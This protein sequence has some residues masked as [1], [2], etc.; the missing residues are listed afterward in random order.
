MLQLEGK[1]F[2]IMGVANK[3]S[4]AWAIA[5][6]LHRAGAQL[7]FSYQGERLEK[8]VRR[9]V[10]EEI[11]GAPC[12]ECDVTSDEQLTTA[13]AEMKELWG[14]LDGVIHSIAFARNEDLE[15]S[16]L[17][18]SRAGYALAQ[19]ISAYSLIAVARAAKPLMVEGGSLITMTYLGAE[20]VIPNYKVMGIAKA[21]LET[22]V[23]YLAEDLGKDNIRVNAISAGPIRTLA[24]RGV[25]DF[26]SILKMMEEKAPLRR[27]TDVEEV[28][29][30]A[31]FLASSL[32][33]GITGEVIHV[34]NGFN[35]IG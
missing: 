34:D 6:A 24:A 4:I 16:F 22:N 2:L 25:K 33:R 20:R 21:A 19:D 27:V 15:G 30:T 17:N 8:Y 9:L 11:P 14:T 7:A 26:N 23:R 32:S 10:D 13:F 3:R 5:K 31:L 29:D 1:R 18:T 28:A 35:L 12:I